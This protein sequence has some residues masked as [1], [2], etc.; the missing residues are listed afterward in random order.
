M[1]VRASLLIVHSYF[2]FLGK[3]L[4]KFLDTC[5]RISCSLNSDYFLIELEGFIQIRLSRLYNNNVNHPNR[6]ISRRNHFLLCES[7]FIFDPK[8][9]TDI[10][11]HTQ[12]ER[13]RYNLFCLNYKTNLSAF[14]SR[15]SNLYPGRNGWKSFQQVIYGCV[16]RFLEIYDRGAFNSVRKKV[17]KPQ[18]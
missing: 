9:N 4:C 8:T 6:L 3:F 13:G 11:A 1:T 14:S 12:R 17:R 15:I 16:T 5:A 18:P 10:Q 7:N 2:N